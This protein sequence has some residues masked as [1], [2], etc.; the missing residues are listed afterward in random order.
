[1]GLFRKIA[2]FYTVGIENSLN[3]YEVCKLQIIN[4]ITVVS[5]GLVFGLIGLNIFIG[6]YIGVG[7]D[8]A[9]LIVVLIPVLLLNYNRHYSLARYWLL[10]GF[11]FAV[12]VGATQA[13]ME[14]RDNEVENLLIPTAIAVL[15]LLEGLGKRI[16]FLVNF[17]AFCG[18]NY[19]RYFSNEELVTAEFYKLLA[20]IVVVYL[21]IYYFIMHFKT[22]LITALKSS[23]KLNAA[24][25]TKE[26]NL[27]ESNKSKDR[28]FSIVAH[29][30]RSPLG[31]IQGLLEP[32]IWKS[33]EKEQHATYLMGVR[34]R[35]GVLQE[36][37]DNLLSW[38]QSQLGSFEIKRTMVDVE[39]EI[40]SVITFFEEMSH[41]K[42]ITVSLEVK[43]A[44]KAYFDIDH[45]NIIMRNVLHNA[46][47]FSPIEG[48]VAVTQYR[49]GEWLCVAIADTG[50]GIDNLTRDK[51]LKS[52]LLES[53]VGTSGEK[54]SGIG[55][56]FCLE[57]IHK[58]K[59]DLKII[60]G[61]KS[62]TVFEVWM[63]I[64]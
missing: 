47:K 62:G 26:Q 7:I 10:F 50:V 30:L 41:A 13:I 57:L 45:L 40:R 25:A 9:V 59:G 36:T 44:E 19:Q 60:E 8:L 38:A 58:N 6:N 48:T 17:L 55:M 49:E 20:I 46:I 18:L 14:G 1:M 24:L 42:Q 53:H 12:C 61:K 4:R 15:I 32:S 63:P 39:K 37:M 11:H 3:T 43:D 51:I 64:N 31:L 23:E 5:I 2:G 35:I 29:D 28:L 34:K 52:H 16:S 27:G 33:M 21:G 22:Q 54:G 56:S